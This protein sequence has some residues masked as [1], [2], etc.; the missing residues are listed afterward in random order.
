MIARTLPHR[1]F[2]DA[3]VL[4]SAAYRAGNGLERLWA[5]NA[6]VTLL[7]SR[8]VIEE[9]LRNLDDPDARDRLDRLVASL[10]L[11]P[12][13]VTGALPVGVDLPDKD[14]PVLLTAI[15][16]GAA[17]LLTGDRAHFGAY[18]GRRLAHVLIQRPG[19]YLNASALRP[20]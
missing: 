6:S 17:H 2:L 10:E 4:F 11:V 14:R 3:N 13:V 20:R 16:A 18:F 15:A 1:L 8:Y 7:G 19:D 9:A 5:A 12:D